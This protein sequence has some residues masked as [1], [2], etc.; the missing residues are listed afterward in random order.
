LELES[1]LANEKEQ[2]KFG[3]LLREVQQNPKF[4]VFRPFPGG[5]RGWGKE[6]EATTV[7]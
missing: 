4:R 6:S 5:K 3:V 1:F 2:A 7:N